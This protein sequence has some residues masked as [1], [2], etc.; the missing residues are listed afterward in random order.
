MKRIAYITALTLLLCGICACGGKEDSS[1]GA[2][3][4]AS[5]NSGN[6]STEMFIEDATD[7]VIVEMP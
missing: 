5:V 2:N 1:A 6:F 4:K 7:A 3:T